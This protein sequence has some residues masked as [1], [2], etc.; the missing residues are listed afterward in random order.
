M[1]EDLRKYKG[2]SGSSCPNTF[3]W[4]Q[5][6]GDAENCYCITISSNLSG[7]Y[8]AAMQ[9][10]EEYMQDHPGRKVAVFDSLSAGPEM[11]L[12]VE[13]IRACLLDGLGFE[14]TVVAVREYQSH[15]RTL[16]C[17]QSLNNLARNGRV[18]PAVAKIAGV[19]GIRVVGKASDHGT[20]EMLHKVRGE[21][22]AM[23]TLFAEIMGNGFHGGKLRISHCQNS[24]S[25]E[26]LKA[27]VLS[28][29]PESDVEILPCTALC[30]F[31]AERGGLIIGYEGA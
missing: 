1:I 20:L 14:D 3:D 28:A 10:A 22:K 26:V 13:K 12:I 11:Q 9:A 15:T 24:E 27:M 2:K 17:L 23:D 30:S 21:R 7:S 5:A 19:L 29:H 31:Y 18:S 16:F 6:F 4:I 25:A 8:S